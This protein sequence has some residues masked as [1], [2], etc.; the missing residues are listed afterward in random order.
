MDNR[1]TGLQHAQDVRLR[2][3]AAVQSSAQ[4]LDLSGGQSRFTWSQ[5]S[6][7]RATISRDVPKNN[8]AD[9]PNVQAQS[10]DALRELVTEIM[11]SGKRRKHELAKSGTFEHFDAAR[12]REHQELREKYESQV[13]I[14]KNYEEDL[15]RL[16][17]M[18][19][20]GSSAQRQEQAE[21]RLKYEEE[22]FQNSK[23]V[24]HLR[25]ANSKIK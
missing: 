9:L 7:V 2:L 23:M 13:K 25:G 8:F 1:S 5:N 3:S 14:I 20:N 15:A 17:K 19:Q 18:L 16:S 6:N 12:M 24:E 10:I 11:L 4:P 21:L 22:K